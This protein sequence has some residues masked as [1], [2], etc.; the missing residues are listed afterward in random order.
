LRKIKPLK[1]G[2]FWWFYFAFMPK[3][4]IFYWKFNKYL[5][6]IEIYLNSCVLLRPLRGW[7]QPPVKHKYLRYKVNAWFR[8]SVDSTCR[9]NLSKV[10]IRIEYTCVQSYE[11]VHMRACVVLS[12]SKKKLQC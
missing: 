8:Q 2:G 9:L 6:N 10:L 4:Q 7:M 11:W 12:F 3:D 1:F 5:K